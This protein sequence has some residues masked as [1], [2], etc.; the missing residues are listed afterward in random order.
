MINTSIKILTFTLLYCFF[1]FL[2]T[3][4]AQDSDTLDFWQSSAFAPSGYPPFTTSLTQD[5]ETGRLTF[6]YTNEPVTGFVSGGRGEWELSTTAGQTATLELFYT[7][8]GHHAFHQ[9]LVSLQAFVED[10]ETVSTF[11]LV[12]EGPESCCTTPS[13][14]FS[15]SGSVILQ[16]NAGQ[17]YGFQ[18]SGSNFDSNAILTGTLTI[19]GATISTP[20]QF[21][22]VV[23][24]QALANA[25]GDK[26]AVTLRA[27]GEPGETS[28]A[29]E[30]MTSAYCFDGDLG[31]DAQVFAQFNIGEFDANGEAFISALVETTEPV[32]NYVTAR[33]AG[34]ETSGEPSVC[35]IAGPDNDS[36]VRALPIELTNSLTTLTAESSISGYLDSP[37]KSRWYKFPIQPGGRATISLSSLP[38]DYDLFVF[39]DIQQ[40]FTSLQ[41]DADIDGLNRLSA[42]FAPSVFSPS[43]FSPSVFS[44]S[45]FSPDAYAPSVFSPSVFSPS[46]FSPSVFSPSV[47]SPSVFSPSVFSPSVFSPSVFSPSVFSPSVFSPS[48]FSPTVFNGENFASAQI[49]ALLAVSAQTGTGSEVVVAD[50]WNN[51]GHFYVRVSGK[52]GASDFST[53]FELSVNLDGV[54]CTGVVPMTGSTSAQANDYQS[55]ILWDSERIIADPDN[56]AADIAQLR[57]KLNEFAARAEIQGA[58]VDLSQINHIQALHEQA[59]EFSSCPYAENLTAF[60]IKELIDDYRSANPSLSYVVILGSDSHVPFFRYPDQGLLGPEQ[61]YDPP[62]ANGT[63]SQSALRLNYILGQDEYGASTILSLRDG[64][65]PIPDLAVGRLVETAAEMNIILDAYLSTPNGV[66]PQ[67]SSTLV[68]G[69]DFLTDAALEVQHELVAG[70][71]DAR[72]DTLITAANI[73]P[74]DPRSWTADDL[75]R[76]LIIEGEDIVFLAGH[77]SANSTLAADYKTTALTTELLDDEV[78][79]TNSIVFSA[80]CHSGYNIVNEDAVPGVTL[81]LDWTQAFAQ[82]GATLIAGTGYQYGDTDFV[83]YSEKLYVGFAKELRTGLGPVSVG[84]ALVRAKQKYLSDTPDIRGL[85]R[86]SILIS[87]V[88]GLPMLKVDLAGERITPP[89]SVANI[90][91]EP[92]V[93]N[94]GALLGL[95][96]ADLPMQFTNSA[97]G[98]TIDRTVT[99]A[100]LEGGNLTATYLLGANGVVSNPAEPAIPLFSRQVGVTGPPLSLRGIGLRGGAWQ[101][102]LVLPLTGAPTTELRGVHTPFTSQVNFPMRIATVNYFGA[103]TGKEP[104]LHVTPAQHRVTNVGDFD[105]ILRQYNDLE[106]RLYYS[107]NTKTYA[108]NVPALSGPPSLS[109]VQAVVDGNDIIFSAKVVGDPASGIHNV[110]VTYT[111]GL[112]STGQWQSLDLT[113]NPTQSTEWTGRLVGQANSFARLDY[114]VQAVSGTGLVTMSDNYGAYYHIAGA[115]GEVG[116]D[117]K[118]TSLDDSNISLVGPVSGQYGQTHTFEATL[119]SESGYIADANILFTIGS[120][121]RAAK[122]DALGK[123]TVQLPLNSL[124]NQYK[125][126]AS[127]SGNDEFGAS[128]A[129][130]AFQ[131]IKAST[132]LTLEQGPQIVEVEGVQS[133]VI[134]KLQD[135]AGTPLLQRTVY[136]TL[137]GGP[138]GTYTIAT[139]TDNT[140]KAKLGNLALPAGSYDITARFLGTIPTYGLPLELS[141]PVYKA[142]HVFTSI[143]L[144]NGQGCEEA[145]AIN[146]NNGM[147][148]DLVGFCYLDANVSEDIM[149]M[150]GTLVLGN[151]VSVNK[152]IVQTGKG[153]VRILQGGIAKNKV[154]ESGPGSIIVAGISSGKLMESDAGGIEIT[155]T[156]RVDKT[157]DEEGNAN[158]KIDE[159]DD[160]NILISGLVSGKVT[161]SGKGDLVVRPT[162]TVKGNASENGLGKLVNQGVIEGKVTQQD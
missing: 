84:Q 79:F 18:L 127:F 91:P 19:N 72:N 20:E 64:S 85:H 124:P 39:K 13:A 34:D 105:A 158:I 71:Q 65:F 160:G 35:I 69:Y 61:D 8:E 120:T 58:I 101:E 96:V 30:L 138:N 92:V 109:G 31:E 117:G 94:P 116:S 67:P 38:D 136:F 16:V 154:V 146:I 51:T 133:G 107:D 115:Q 125:L 54:D 118:P 41:G 151:G 102:R 68:T 111:E 131:I 27:S 152:K 53:P 77:F 86:K 121:G 60:A 89:A 110:W 103:L 15:Y 40:A 147:Q 17:R 137:E 153:S 57:A 42:E 126:T 11:P 132:N 6:F 1:C 9:V 80:G 144:V 7:Y 55:I 5:A 76:E 140:G 119:N 22:E 50:T 104:I 78:D 122:T 43:V 24:L 129:E 83:E 128:S 52:N 66:I 106:F 114:I 135:A 28:Q 75:R 142:S 113:Q 70:T 159:Q 62:M 112:A 36:W 156:G 47:F 37:G 157:I 14:G 141:D 150:D 95:Q 32:S 123:A 59:D 73:S 2:N 161:E 74:D 155:A 12:N 29:I 143:N 162:G 26:A 93:N 100:N 63:Q 88:F 33:I 97:D 4:T 99:L 82:K 48:V 56:S 81:T 25:E 87:T 149:I 90:E 49:R 98:A 145:T 130:Q 44:P 45:V 21:G 23:L 10:G 108:Q 3:S 46:V 139:I 134:A 148:N